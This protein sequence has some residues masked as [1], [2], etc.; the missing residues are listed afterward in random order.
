[1]NRSDNSSFHLTL[2]AVWRH[3]QV[4]GSEPVSAVA[5][6]LSPIRW[7]ADVRVLILLFI[8]ALG[9]ATP[10]PRDV[11]ISPKQVGVFE[12]RRPQPHAV[13]P[14][15]S[16]TFKQKFVR[17]TQQVPAALGT[18][19][20]LT[21]RISTKPPRRYVELL[22]IW[23][24]PPLTDPDTGVTTTEIEH[25]QTLPTNTVLPVLYLFDYPWELAPGTWT[26]EI[27]HLEELIF[28]A[29]FDVVSP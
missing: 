22:I 8:S 20:G 26:V 15:R 5:A 7:A 13:Y 21:L 29:D 9:C 23:R 1:M 25:S 11:T 17:E 16:A 14:S 10:P 28:A 2:G 27:R 24:S 12:T 6:R 4:A 18:G 3:S 19:F